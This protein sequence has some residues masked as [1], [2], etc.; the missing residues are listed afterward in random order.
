[1]LPALVPAFAEPN[2]IR[3]L[4]PGEPLQKIEL[5]FAASPETIRREPREYD[6]VAQDLA[7]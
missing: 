7:A 2:I 5:V 6:S 4:G 1:V 3:R